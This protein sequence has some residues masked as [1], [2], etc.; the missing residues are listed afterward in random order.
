MGSGPRV[1]GWAAAFGGD[2]EARRFAPCAAVC[3]LRTRRPTPKEHDSWARA[4]VSEARQ[5]LSAEMK[6]CDSPLLTRR[7][8]F[9]AHGG[10]RPRSMTRGPGPP[11]QRLG[12]LGARQARFSAV[13]WGVNGGVLL[14]KDSPECGSHSFHLPHPFAFE[15]SALFCRCSCHGLARPS[16]VL[17]AR[18]GTQLGAQPARMGCA[19]IRRKDPCRRLS[20]QRSRRRRVRALR[21]EPPLQVGVADLVL[22]RTAAWRSSAPNLSTSRPAS[23]S[24]RPSTSSRCPWGRRFFR[25]HSD[26]KGLVQRPSEGE[27]RAKLRLH[28]SRELHQRPM[29]HLHEL[30]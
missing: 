12:R 7:F 28:L 29:V 23:S 17:P 26:E 15:L 27:K 3:L 9:F 21:L 19:S 6:R 4:P 18:G 8:A 5:L 2:E 1:R 25:Q 10:R 16:R 13:S 24:R 14:K 22:L 20:P 11:C 30:V